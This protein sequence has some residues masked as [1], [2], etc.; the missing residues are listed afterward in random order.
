MDQQRA[1]TLLGEAAA[2]SVENH[3]RLGLGSG[4]TVAAC[5]TALARRVRDDNLVLHLVVASKVS[6]RLAEAHGLL[7][8]SDELRGSLDYAIDGA[9]FVDPTGILIKGGGGALV[10]ERMILDSADRTL[11][12]VDASKPVGHL[13]GCKIPVAVVPFGWQIVLEKLKRLG[14]SVRLRYNRS[15][16]FLTDDGLWIL[17]TVW[18]SIPSPEALH[19][20][21]KSLP[22]VV[23]TGIFVGYQQEVWMSEGHTVSPWRPLKG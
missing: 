3:M 22:G 10:R 23:D 6:G 11:I 4:S 19:H 14:A 12:L 20:Q 8:V 1:K 2:K 15:E 13:E 18:N 7:V 17:D 16:P 9:D 5:I 21:L